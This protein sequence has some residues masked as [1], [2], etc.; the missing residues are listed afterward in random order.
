[1]PAGQLV[2]G[3]EENADQFSWQRQ[4]AT[5]RGAHQNL[6]LLWHHSRSLG[7]GILM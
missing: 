1:M 2:G 4:L 6:N 7:E 3:G 5:I